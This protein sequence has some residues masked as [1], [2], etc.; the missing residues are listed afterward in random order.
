MTHAEKLLHKAERAFVPETA[1]KYIH[2]ATTNADQQP[3]RAEKFASY[4]TNAYL[5]FALF[6]IA[7]EVQK[8]QISNL[9]HDNL[10]LAQQYTDAGSVQDGLLKIDRATIALRSN[11]RPNHY[12]AIAG[13]RQITRDAQESELALQ[14]SLRLYAVA[15]LHYQ[16]NLYKPAEEEIHCLMPDRTQCIYSYSQSL[17]ACPTRRHSRSD[18]ALSFPSVDYQI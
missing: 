10:N 17:D 6:P 3:D 14:S 13:L 11:Q 4:R 12:S 18:H 5:A 16:E 7:R 1:L 2:L 9:I 8:R 15:F